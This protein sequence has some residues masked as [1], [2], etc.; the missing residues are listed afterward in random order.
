[1]GAQPIISDPLFHSVAVP[2]DECTAG[3]GLSDLEDASI[4][5]PKQTNP[6]LYRKLQMQMEND[7]PFCHLSNRLQPAQKTALEPL[8]GQASNDPTKGV[9]GRD[10]E[11]T[12]P[13]VTDDLQ[14]TRSLPHLS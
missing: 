14:C 8:G 13:P 6:E 10:A 5:R 7:F 4:P 12:S 11:T 1:V 2:F 3:R 9:V